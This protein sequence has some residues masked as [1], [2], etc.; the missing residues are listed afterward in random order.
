VPFS[1]VTVSVRFHGLKATSHVHVTRTGTFGVGIQGVHWCQNLTVAARDTAGHHVVLHGTIPISACAPPGAGTKVLL[2]FLTPKQ[3]QAK[4]IT[5]DTTKAIEST[6][7]HVGDVLYVY[8]AG[9]SQPSVTLSPDEAHF[10]LIEQGKIPDCPP[11][12]SCPFPPGFFWRLV[13]TQPGDAIV[14]LSPA[15]RQ[16]KPP[17]MLPDRAVRVTILP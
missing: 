9:T 2:H 6:A 10:R 7:M 17:C 13:A 8:A 15:C 3:M 16:S 14:A 1:R 11:T 5:V 4:Q 12:A